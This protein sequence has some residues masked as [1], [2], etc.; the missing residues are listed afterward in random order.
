VKL[1]EP[2]HV[3]AEV[4]DAIADRHG[5]KADQCQQLPDAGIFNSVYVLGERLVLRV[6][7]NHP[8]HVDALYREVTIVPAARAAGVRTPALLA[9]DDT[10]D[11]LPVPY[12]I[13]ERVPGQT[14]ESLGLDPPQAAPVWRE[15]GRDLAR[16][17]GTQAADLPEQEALPDPRDLL[18]RHATKGWFTSVEVRWL[19]SWLDRLAT[20]APPASGTCVLHGDSQATNVMVQAHPLEY[21]AVIDWG[22]AGWGDVAND[23]AGVPLRAVPFMLDGHRELAP[24]D[25]GIEARIVLRHLQLMLLILPRGAVPGRSWAE[26]PLPMLLEILRFFLAQPGGPW[27][28]LGPG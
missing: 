27:A 25:D 7:R 20:L 4:L 5:V 22:G 9:L 6:P 18:E 26:R 10:C 17:H 11:L 21:R 15:L 14:L 24:L 19:K 28:K 1:P 16:L 8:W 13:Y 23:F 2:T 3:S 12:A